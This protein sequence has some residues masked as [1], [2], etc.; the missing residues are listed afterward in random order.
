MSSSSARFVPTSSSMD[1]PFLALAKSSACFLR[2]SSITTT[3]APGVDVPIAHSATGVGGGASLTKLNGEPAAESA[4]VSASAAKRF[5]RLGNVGGAPKVSKFTSNSAFQGTA[6][7]DASK[8]M[9]L[10]PASHVSPHPSN[11]RA[12][13]VPTD[14]FRQ[15]LF[16]S[17]NGTYV[18]AAGFGA[19]SSQAAADSTAPGLSQGSSVEDAAPLA[20][21]APA[22]T[23]G[24][25]IGVSQVPTDGLRWKGCSIVT[26]CPPASSEE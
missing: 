4:L 9:P 10:S 7:R 19:G 16:L 8:T 2:L 1:S 17:A 21:G 22:A 24:R 15:Y 14:G 3:S 26:S 12:S 11:F 25:C 5:L 20:P 18:G 6:G 23:V 13:Q